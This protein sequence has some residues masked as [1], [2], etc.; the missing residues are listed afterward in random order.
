M[1][2]VC[3]HQDYYDLL[4]STLFCCYY[5]GIVLAEVAEQKL[6]CSSSVA[7]QLVGKKSCIGVTDLAMQHFPLQLSGIAE[8][9]PPNS[10]SRYC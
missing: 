10:P 5:T 6:P 2:P 4:F 9:R 7:T 1:V 8:T 3:R